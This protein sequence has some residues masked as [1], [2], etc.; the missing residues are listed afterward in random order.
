MNLLLRSLVGKPQKVFF[1]WA[2]IQL[3]SNVHS[4]N[5]DLLA[6]LRLGGGGER[7]GGASDDLQ[8]TP[9]HLL[10]VSFFGPRI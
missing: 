5:P 1:P 6:M 8:G 2:I 4:H 10:P 7:G 9:N 3:L